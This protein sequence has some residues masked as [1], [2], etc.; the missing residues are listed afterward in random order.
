MI[1]KPRDWQQHALISIA[2]AVAET[3][4]TP[5]QLTNAYRVLTTEVELTNDYSG[6]G[7]AYVNYRR[8]AINCSNERELSQFEL[9]EKSYFEALRKFQQFGIMK[10]HKV[11]QLLVRDLSVDDERVWLN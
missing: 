2:G 7:K 11:A 9:F 8:V 1:G 6:F 3:Y 5:S 4:F 10:M